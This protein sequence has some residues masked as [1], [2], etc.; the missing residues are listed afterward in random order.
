MLRHLRR[1]AKFNVVSDEHGHVKRWLRYCMVLMCNVVL[2]DHGCLTS[3]P[4]AHD[5]WSTWGVC[6]NFS[7]CLQGRRGK[8]LVSSVVTTGAMGHVEVRAKM[9]IV[10]HYLQ[11][12]L[13]SSPMAGSF[14]VVSTNSDAWRRVGR[15]CYQKCLTSSPTGAMLRVVSRQLWRV[16]RRGAKE[17]PTITNA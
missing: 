5:A 13:E 6:T 16:T 2:E 12:C 11:K 9:A 4:T 1:S 8:L 10:L 3:L 7:P 17:F 14:W 15:K